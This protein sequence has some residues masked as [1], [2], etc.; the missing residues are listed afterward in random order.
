MTQHT[1]SSNRVSLIFGRDPLTIEKITNRLT[2]KTI[3]L[4][5]TQTVLVRSPQDI[6]EPALLVHGRFL[7]AKEGWAYELSDDTGKYRAEI[8]LEHSADGLRFS[9]R[10][11]SPKPIWLVEWRLS[12]MQADEIIVPALGGQSLDRSMPTDTTISY[13]YPFWWN[14]QFAIGASKRGGFWIRS[15]ETEPRLKMLRVKNESAGFAI[16][17]GFEAM[18]P[19]GAKTLDAVWYLDGYAGSWE[20]P[21]DTHRAWLEEAFS[22]LPLAKNPRWPLWASDINFVLELWGMRKDSATPHHTFDQMIDR[23]KA[24]KRL[25]DPRKTLVYLPGFAEHGIDSHA[26]DYNPSSHLGGPKKFAQLVKAAHRMGY[27]VMIHTNAIA[28]TFT[29]R[30][31]PKLKKHQVVDPFGRLQGWGLD[32]D[33]DW[34]FEPYFAYINPGTKEWGELMQKI[35]GHLIRTYGVDGV[36][37][38]QTL[39]AFN[40]SRGP[41]FQTGMNQHVQRLEKAFPNVL[42]AGEGLHELVLSALPMAQIHGLDSITEVHGL[43]GKTRW[44]NIHP[45]NARLFES[46]TRFTAHLLTRHPSN[47]AFALQES[48]YAQLG[49]L[50]ALC[51]YNAAQKMDLPEVRKMVKRARKLGIKKQTHRSRP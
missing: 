18:A 39:L 7:R 13:K 42:F 38:D 12:G 44:R 15:K 35:L 32:L 37:L 8:R 31:Y 16:T 40:N 45:V 10:V 33:G 4:D 2:G 47:P 36:F 48:Y 28:M 29:H 41:N 25:H 27:R 9:M 43:E 14:A 23:L 30:L 26:P 17:Y 46:F 5:G 34:L 19:L 22:L 49:V 1:P 51:L 21:V 24:W 50:P 6:S 3:C 11:R 20:E